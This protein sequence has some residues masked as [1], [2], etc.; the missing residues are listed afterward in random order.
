M[1]TY[2]IIESTTFEVE[3]NNEHEAKEKVLHCA[4]GKYIGHRCRAL[5]V[6]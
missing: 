5:K 2:R 4:E 6:I 1:P 3:A